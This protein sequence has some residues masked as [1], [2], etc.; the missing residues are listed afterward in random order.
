M[1]VKN[2]LI[3]DDHALLVEGIIATLKEKITIENVQVCYSPEEAIECAARET[4]D[5]YILDLSFRTSSNIDLRCF[6][7][8]RQISQFDTDARIIVYTMRDDFTVVSILSKIKNIRGI[9]LKGPEKKYLQEAAETVLKGGDYLCPRFRNIHQRS[10]EYRKRLGKKKMVN[11]LPTEKEIAIIKLLAA[12]QTS[13]DIAHT[14]GHT[15][16]TIESY[17]RDLKIKFNVSNTLDMVIMAILLNYITLD[18]V[19]LNL[20]KD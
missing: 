2:V 13:E 9:V 14:L 6:D 11:G 18:E 3:T 20:L 19:A 15:T 16:S 12:G 7:Y 5:L 10:E 1:D 8:L 4:Y 17:R